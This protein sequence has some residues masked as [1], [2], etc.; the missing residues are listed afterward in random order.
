MIKEVHLKYLEAGS[1]IITTNTFGAN[2]LKLKKYSIEDKTIE[3]NLRNTKI[4]QEINTNKK[5]LIAGDIGPTGEFLEP[6]GDFTYDQFIDVFSEQAKALEDGGADVIIIETM[7]FI[8]EFKAAI[9]AIK[10][11]TNLPIIGCMAFNKKP[12]GFFTLGGNT[13]TQLVD[14]ATELNIDAVG[15]NCNLNPADII[16]LTLELIKITDI[17]IVIQPNAGNPKVVEGKTIYEHIPNLAECLTNI[18]K[19]GVSIVGGCCGTD[20]NYIKLLRKIVDEE[21]PNK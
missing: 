14:A 9:E 7:M 20:E 6:F 10:K 16:P 18:F 19:A 5:I 12:N 4:A 1:D 2:R 21:S 13:P 17:P 3:I 8:D 15:A 11:S